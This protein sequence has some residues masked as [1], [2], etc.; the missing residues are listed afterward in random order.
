MLSRTSKSLKRLM[1]NEILIIQLLCK[2]TY[3]RAMINYILT[4]SKTTHFYS[5]S[6]V[7][8]CL[9]K[10][11]NYY[12]W[13]VYLLF[14]LLCLLKILKWMITIFLIQALTQILSLLW[15]NEY[16]LFYKMLLD[17]NNKFSTLRAVFCNKY[18]TFLLESAMIIKMW[19]FLVSYYCLIVKFIMIGKYEF[20]S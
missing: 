14:N 3:A 1:I 17:K 10:I 11:Y 5:V 20:Q 18:H 16:R 2:S 13:D 6:C 12:I 19:P 8:V 15:L 7:C 9:Y 4:T